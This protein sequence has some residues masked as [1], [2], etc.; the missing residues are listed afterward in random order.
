[1]TWQETAVLQGARDP[2]VSATF[3][4]DGRTLASCGSDGWVRVWDLPQGRGEM[5]VSQ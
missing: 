4:P 1:V 2:V 5:V 3:A